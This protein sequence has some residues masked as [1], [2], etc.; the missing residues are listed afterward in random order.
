[1]TVELQVINTP[2]VIDLIDNYMV[3]CD[4]K[5]TINAQ[6]L[7]ASYGNNVFIDYDVFI[8]GQKFD[9]SMSLTMTLNFTTGDPVEIPVEI[10]NKLVSTCNKIVYLEVRQ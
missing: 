1:M 7:K 6:V 10:R 8:N 3:D 2:N 9:A 5:F 4:R